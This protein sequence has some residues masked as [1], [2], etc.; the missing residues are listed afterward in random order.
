MNRADVLDFQARSQVISLRRL[1]YTANDI[2]E[3]LGLLSGQERDAVRSLCETSK[4]QNPRW[5][6]RVSINRQLTER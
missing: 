6:P 2:A 4:K 3:Q 5:A 1:G